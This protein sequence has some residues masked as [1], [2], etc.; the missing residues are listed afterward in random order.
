MAEVGE[1]ESSEKTQQE[2]LIQTRLPSRLLAEIDRA[3]TITGRNRREITIVEWLNWAL[4]SVDA[5]TG[6]LPKVHPETGRTLGEI[7]NHPMQTFKGIK[8]PQR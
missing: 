3:T 7:K 2:R 4:E 1:T 5:E 6:N 8:R